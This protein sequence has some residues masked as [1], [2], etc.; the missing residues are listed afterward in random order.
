M[1]IIAYQRTDNGEYECIYIHPDTKYHHSF[2]VDSLN[3]FGDFLELH[4]ILKLEPFIDIRT[5][6]SVM[7]NKMEEETN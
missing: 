6:I 1:K 4:N 3:M 5:W 2:I 7:D